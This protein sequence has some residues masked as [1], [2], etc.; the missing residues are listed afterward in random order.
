MTQQVQLPYAGPA[1]GV[2]QNYVRSRRKLS[3]D[4][5]KKFHTKWDEADNSF[6][7][8]QPTSEVDAARKAQKRATGKHDYVTITVP[9]TFA[10]IMTAHTYWTS[11]FLSRNPV[12]QVAG[13]HGES[14]D[15]EEALEAALEYQLTV[16]HQL[17]PLFNW[18][19]DMAKYGF[20]VSCNYWDVEEKR[21]RRIIE[22]PATLY[23]IP[24]VGRM[25]KVEQEEVFTSFE[26]N[27][28]FCVRPYDF[29][30]DPRVAMTEFQRGEFCG[31]DTQVGWHE[32][33]EG[34]R[35]GRYFNVD[36][37]ARKLNENIGA[38]DYL[39]TEGSS[40]VELPDKPGEQPLGENVGPGFVRLH[41][42]YGRV[43][44]KVLGINA[45]PNVEMW[46]FVLANNEVIIGAEP[47]GEYHQMFP[48]NVMEFGQGAHEFLKISLQ[49]VI[50][51]LVDTISWLFNSHFYNVRKALND[52]RVV[53][54]SRV[55]MRDLTS[56]VE[57]GIVRLKP[58][59][60]GTPTK[61]A[62]H[63]LITPDMTRTHIQD[64]TFIE[65]FL[66][67]ISGVVDTLFGTPEGPDRESA[68]GVRTRTGFA[69]NRLKTVA[70]YN[71]ALGMVPHVA[72]LISNTQQYMSIEQKFRVAGASSL[73]H[74]KSFVEVN[75]QLI[76]G[77][78]DYIP[79]DGTMPIDRLAQANFWKELAIQLAQSPIG[80]TWD[81]NEMIAHIMHL[82]GEKNVERFRLDMQS[83]ED[84]EQAV[85]QGN[86]VPIGGGQRGGGNRPNTGG[87][88]GATI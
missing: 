54:P 84:I 85:Q 50:Q 13:R 49:E 35:Q 51:P 73:R 26:G 27:R 58:E 18:I 16:G 70:E 1:H 20:G 61:D 19:F 86:I 25:E 14:K 56:P 68:T 7:A 42:M 31:R 53:D 87:A 22:K 39:Y 4:K 64:A 29:F 60:Y 77:Q 79:V 34:K 2:V 52:V 28:V 41:E 83:P 3:A 59:A 65:I 81:L 66:Q 33:L 24:L 12:Y 75:P 45:S 5:M 72:Q 82:Q 40:N 9:Y 37:L 32:I 21:V 76:A 38:G 67:K 46:K 74:A 17:V 23:G 80:A 78:F 63:Q 43:I 10:I 71:S 30:P 88:S 15:S 55:V 69:A 36:I 6:R 44:P 11:V 8:Y 62:V 47:V 48:F 57:R